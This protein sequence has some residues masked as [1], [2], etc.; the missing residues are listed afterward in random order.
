M[1]M[2]DFV[3]EQNVLRFSQLIEAEHDTAKRQRLG[4]LLLDQ[5]NQFAATA[6]RLDKTDRHIAE[7]KA[8]IGRPYGL[9]DKLRIDGRDIQSAE[10]LLRNLMELHDLFVGHRQVL[11]EGL[12]RR[13]F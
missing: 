5:E 9:I 8:R 1:D 12:N 4:S 6:E 11:L 3:R 10:R 13:A 7:C 2:D